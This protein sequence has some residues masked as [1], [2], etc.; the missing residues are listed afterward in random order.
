MRISLG[1][2]THRVDLG[3]QFQS[4]AAIMELSRAAEDGGYDAV[5]VTEHPFPDARWLEH[6]GHHALDP[7]VSLSFA[8]AATT[9]LRLQTNL[10]VLAYRNSAPCAGHPSRPISR[11]PS[12]A[13]R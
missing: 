11:G 8:A 7:Y 13:R 3:A 1:L 9:R 5:Y 12:A 6:G 4:G 2:P 10:V